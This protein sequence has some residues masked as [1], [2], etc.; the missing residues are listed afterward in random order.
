MAAL[1]G[2][3]AAAGAVLDDPAAYGGANF[4]AGAPSG[5]PAWW[6]ATMDQRARQPFSFGRGLLYPPI[7]PAPPIRPVTPYG[8]PPAAGLLGVQNT[9]ADRLFGPFARFGPGSG[10]A[11]GPQL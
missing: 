11:Q 10:A 8:P 9:R 4:Y 3:L 7:Y 6:P 2:P 1:F 5:A